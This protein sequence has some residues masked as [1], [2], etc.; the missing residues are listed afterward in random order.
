[1][2]DVESH[3]GARGSRAADRPYPKG[4][5]APA[6]LRTAIAEA[7]RTRLPL[8]L[9]LAVL[10]LGTAAGGVLAAAWLIR[11]DVLLAPAVILLLILVGRQMRA[12]E[13]MVH[14]GSHFNWSRRRRTVN[15]VL[16]TILAGAP[17]GATIAAYRTSHLLHHGRF[18]TAD[19]PDRQRYEELDI[20]RLSRR[21][22]VRDVLV[23][24]PRYQVGWFATMK[25][26]PVRIALPVAATTVL[27]AAAGYLVLGTFGGAL[28]ALFWLTGYFGTLP[29]LRLLGEASE[30]VYSGSD[31]VFDA[32]ITNLGRWQRL[33]LHPHNDGYHTIHH[34]WP[35]VPHHSIR[36]LHNLLLARDPDGYGRRLRYRTRLLETPR[37]GVP[38]KGTD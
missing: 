13:N 15:D 14:E 20:E 12:L 24:L 34:M 28:T 37:R 33:L 10:D 29:V 21:G 6:H 5:T 38:Q 22:L 30:H 19:D 35:G 3:G 36:K 18:G 7:H 17:T 9:T 11:V 2:L 32:T 4:Y 31:T 26:Q 23:R 25:A 1:M 27:V 16:A 8:T